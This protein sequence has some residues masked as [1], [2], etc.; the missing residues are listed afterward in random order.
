MTNWSES[1]AATSHLDSCHTWIVLS[2]P[3]ERLRS[4]AALDFPRPSCFLGRAF[5]RPPMSDAILLD[6]PKCGRKIGIADASGTIHV[7]C[8]SC[9]AQ[10]DWDNGRAAAMGAKWRSGKRQFT[11]IARRAANWCQAVL[12]PPRFSFVQVGIALICGVGIGLLAGI[13]LGMRSTSSD[14]QT[15]P[16]AGEVGVAGSSSTNIFELPNTDAKPD[17]SSPNTKASQTNSR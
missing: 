1:S 11:G 16:T 10:W 13:W 7:T 8:P 12:L 17:K 6:C 14:P 4:R 5:V 9:K 2:S 15:E 3:A